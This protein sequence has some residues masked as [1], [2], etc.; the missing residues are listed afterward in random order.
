MSILGIDHVQLAMPLNGEDTARSFYGS[1]LGM[2][3]LAKPVNLA[4]RGGVWFACGLL[5]LHLGVEKDFRPAR[6][7]HPALLVDDYP[8][9]LNR[10]RQANYTLQEDDSLPGVV[11]CFV[12]DPFGNRIELIAATYG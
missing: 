9:L 6:K 5:Q 7:A 8:D 1:I 11:R 2:E 12:D 3:E 10:L 4:A